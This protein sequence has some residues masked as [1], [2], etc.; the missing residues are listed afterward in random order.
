MK[1]VIVASENPV[2]I[3]VAKRAFQSVYPHE[4]F[5]F[6]AMKSESGVPDQPMNEETK[7]GASNRLDFVRN[8]YPDADF[9]I[10]QEGGLFEEGTRMYNRAWIM[11]RDSTGHI[12]ESSTACFYLPSKIVSYVREGMELGHANDVFFGSSNSKEGKGAIGYLTDGLIHREDY[13]VQSAIIALSELKHKD[14][15]SHE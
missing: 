2:K 3:N 8:A 6:V 14:W 12:T 10:S 1:K 11:V 5:E 4:S 15:Y 9:W 7:Q 13:Y